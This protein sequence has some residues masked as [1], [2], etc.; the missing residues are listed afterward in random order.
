M[1]SEERGTAATLLGLALWLALPAAA[2]DVVDDA[3]L[4]RDD[5]PAVSCDWDACP[6][7]DPRHD[8]PILDTHWGP[9]D[10]DLVEQRL[11]IPLGSSHDRRVI[12]IAH[13]PG[14]DPEEP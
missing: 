11:H 10:P 5:L 13:R 7:R 8:D 6:W 12:D 2:A 14:D 4:R 9:G 1:R 3:R